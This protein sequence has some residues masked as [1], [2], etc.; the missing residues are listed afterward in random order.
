MRKLFESIFYG[1][2]K[3]EQDWNCLEAN[4]F[5]ARFPGMMPPYKYT[6]GCPVTEITGTTNIIGSGDVNTNLIVAGCATAH[7]AAKAARLSRGGFDDWYLPNGAE[8]KA[9]YQQKSVIP[10]FGGTNISYWT[11]YE[12]DDDSAYFMQNGNVIAAAKTFELRVR[13][14]HK[15]L[16]DYKIGDTGPGG[17]IIFYTKPSTP[18]HKISIYDTELK[19]NDSAVDVVVESPGYTVNWNAGVNDVVKGGIV[20]SSGEFTIRNIDGVLTKF[21][22][23][24]ASQ[25]EGRYIVEFQK[26]TV[27]TETWESFWKGVLMPD[28]SARADIPDEPISFQATDGIALLDAIELTS[29]DSELMLITII[30]GLRQIPTERLFPLLPETRFL[31]AKTQWFSDALTEDSEPLF[32]IGM[33]GKSLW[34]KKEI[35]EGYSGEIAVNIV[36]MTYKEVIQHI[37]ERFNAI[38]IMQQ[39]AWYLFQRDAIASADTITFE[40]F[41]SYPSLGNWRTIPSTTTVPCVKEIDQSNR[42]RSG[43]EFFWLPGLK[44]VETVYGGGNFADGFDSLIPNGFLLGQTYTTMPLR[45][46]TGNYLHIRISFRERYSIDWAGAYAPEQ[47]FAA[48]VYY[49]VTVRCGSYYLNAGTGAWS[50]NSAASNL[51]MPSNTRLERYCHT[52]TGQWIF[53]DQISYMKNLITQDLPADAEVTFKMERVSILVHYGGDYFTASINE[54]F[55]YQ[56]DVE[57]HFMLYIVDNEAPVDHV[58][59]TADNPTT[60]FQLEIDLGEG[61]FGT[62]RVIQNRVIGANNAGGELWGRGYSSTKTKFFNELLVHE[63]MKAQTKGLMCITSQILERNA[64]YMHIWQAIEIKINYTT[65]RFHF[66]NVTYNAH[67]ETWEGD[68]F[69]IYRGK[70]TIFPDIIT[71]KLRPDSGLN[72]Y[73]PYSPVVI[74]G[75]SNVWNISDQSIDLTQKGINEDAG[76]TTNETILAIRSFIP[77]PSANKTLIA[78]DK[79]GV[80]KQVDSFGITKIVGE[81][82]SKVIPNPD[83]EIYDGFLYNW[84][85]TQE[86]ALISLTGLTDGWDVPTQ[87]ELD[88]LIK[89]LIYAGYNYDDSVVNNKIGKALTT[90]SGWNVSAVEGAIGNTDYPA[91]R[92]VT[93]FGLRP[94]GVRESDGGFVHAGKF[95]ILWTKTELPPSEN[96]IYFISSC[97]S[98]DFQSGNTSKINGFSI[99]LFRTASKKEQALKD[100]TA[101][102][103]AYTGNDGKVYQG[104]RL[105]AHIWLSENLA[106]TKYNTG[107]EIPECQDADIWE[108]L[109]VPARCSYD[110]DPTKAFLDSGEVIFKD[111]KKLP[112]DQIS[113]IS[114]KA[115]T[116]A[117][118]GA[119]RYRSDAS[120]SYAEMVM[121][122]AEGKW[123]WVVIKQIRF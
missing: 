102:A 88:N 52:E 6:W 47:Q 117:I 29:E 25:P 121:E 10:F 103:N 5:D 106:E 60:G 35:K 67:T 87:A 96:A 14:I 78:A 28:F 43:S 74:Q 11:S 82:A 122:V 112:S 86:A 15:V 56:P 13:P 70:A 55:D 8:M 17:G 118:A 120:A 105:G 2:Q 27:E 99:R 108:G 97:D 90:D 94:T 21:L 31:W 4:T 107:V 113:Y 92:N 119:I 58:V 44:S 68:W 32:Q 30:K 49:K 77:T 34:V 69:E 85:V 100:G 12:D 51:I 54:H 91:K 110:N 62:A 76:I 93:G 20:E 109:T 123:D 38:L 45:S 65:Y 80:L 40:T 64:D 84:Y 26:R 9:M 116:E 115:P 18:L 39:G 33:F 66:N 24:L 1:K 83:V 48:T 37:C 81:Q 98:V 46:G 57:N 41:H 79:N 63:V 89:Y 111:G 19:E 22:F 50:L 53:I 75:L 95:G 71:D 23:N 104:V 59:F 61:L 73:L 114:N 101:I 16:G 3:L 72:P 7:I 36:P 42:Y